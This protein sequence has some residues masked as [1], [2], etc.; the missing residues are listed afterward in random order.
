M[1]AAFFLHPDIAPN[2]LVIPD[3]AQRNR[4]FVLRKT[5][6][7]GRAKWE[8]ADGRQYTRPSL[9]YVDSGSP[10]DAAGMLKRELF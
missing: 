1:R 5:T 8:S 9:H 4:G 6:I 10:L 7:S 3:G 2:R